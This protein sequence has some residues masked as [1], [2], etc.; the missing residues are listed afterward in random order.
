M[1]FRSSCA[2]VLHTM[3][4]AQHHA[5]GA[6]VSVVRESAR[7]PHPQPCVERGN[8]C[9]H[10]RGSHTR[11]RVGRSC[12]DA[13]ACAPPRAIRGRHALSARLSLAAISSESLRGAR[14]R[15]HV[16]SGAPRPLDLARASLSLAPNAAQGTPRAWTQPHPTHNELWR[17]RRCGG[18]CASAL[19]DA[20]AREREGM[21]Y[22]SRV[23]RSSRRRGCSCARASLSLSLYIY[24]CLSL[25]VYVC[26][27]VRVCV[28]ARVRAS[29]FAGA[30]VCVSVLV[31]A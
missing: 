14:T 9:S 18:R 20:M 7:A 1:D 6:R 27:R 12:S 8:D 26:A 22:G 21:T 24:V 30:R 5:L 4:S 25:C 23:L 2:H 29:A 13:P 16:C 11:P 28:C 19:G 31:R 17:A 10:S 15:T 3:P